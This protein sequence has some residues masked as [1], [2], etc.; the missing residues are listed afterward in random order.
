M[1]ILLRNDNSKVS[2]FSENPF[3]LNWNNENEAYY[4]IDYILPNED[5]EDINIIQKKKD[6][7]EKYNFEKIIKKYDLSDFI[8]IIF[9]KKESELNVLSKVFLNKEYKVLNSK[10]K[11]FDLNNSNIVNKVIK[12]LKINY[13]DEWKKINQINSSINLTITLSLDNKEYDLINKFEKKIKN[14]DLVSNYYI[15]MFSEKRTIYK[16][17]FNGT[18]DKF[19]NEITTDGFDLETSSAVWIVK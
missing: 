4:L 15:E 18:P 17:V 9:F 11:N 7:L 8:I 12:N 5:I 2:L 19:I 6:E 14:L 16:V 1:P 13:E 3:F 10:F